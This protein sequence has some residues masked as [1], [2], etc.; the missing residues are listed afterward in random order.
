MN[1]NHLMVMAVLTITSSLALLQA[2]IMMTFTA[3]MN[4]GA[5]G[6]EDKAGIRALAV[7]SHPDFEETPL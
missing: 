2:R 3:S 5:V 6:F 1:T 4:S 7:T